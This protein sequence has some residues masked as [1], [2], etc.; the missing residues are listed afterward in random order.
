MD[1]EH[2]CQVFSYNPEKVNRVKE[3]MDQ[4]NIKKMA[5]IFK[6]LSDE[7]RAKIAWALHQEGELCVCDISQIIGS[8]VATASHHLRLLHNMGLAKK[9]KKGR[10][11]HYSLPCE[12]LQEIINIAHKHCEVT[13]SYG[14]EPHT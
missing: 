8:S 13:L 1:E 12:H 3:K 7:T 14:R 2:R 11:V 10:Y 4:E 5:K 6:A 9:R